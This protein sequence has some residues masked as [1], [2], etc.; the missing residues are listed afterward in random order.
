[1]WPTLL[2]VHVQQCGSHPRGRGAKQVRDSATALCSMAEATPLGTRTDA[3]AGGRSLSAEEPLRWLALR[4]GWWLQGAKNTLCKCHRTFPRSQSSAPLRGR[5]SAVP[6]S[7]TNGPPVAPALSV[8]SSSSPLAMPS[9]ALG[10]HA[11]SCARGNRGGRHVLS[12]S[13]YISHTRSIDRCVP[14][15]E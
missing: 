14:A 5:R 3:A 13:P 10:G 4:G 1:M 12:P 15:M 11:H 6:P 9:R 7:V 8:P 2:G